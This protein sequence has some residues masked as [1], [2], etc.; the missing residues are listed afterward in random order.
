MVPF[1]FFLSLLALIVQG[2]FLPKIAI[3]AMSPFL[4]L[5]ILKEPFERALYLSVAAGIVMDLLSDDPMGIHA[6]N[7][8]II[9]FVLFRIKNHFLHDQ[10]LHL[11]L[12]TALISI[13]S[14]LLQLLL[15][16]LFDRRVPLVGRW[17]FSQLIA[18]SM[19]DALYAFVWF[20]AP[21]ALV[22]K[23]RQ[24]WVVFW[25]RRK[26]LSRTSH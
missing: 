5:V 23:I 13:A 22:N 4:S 11:S 12:F 1:A 21:L 8:S 6:L 15:L 2:V 24:I 3:L 9:C 10:P 19:V 18:V 20:S 26:R 14:T 17:I 7:Y 25:L 16:F